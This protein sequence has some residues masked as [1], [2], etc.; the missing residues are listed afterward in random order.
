MTDAK[1][2]VRADEPGASGLG[3]VDPLRIP[4]LER[5][6]RAWQQL[7]ALGRAF[8][9]LA[10]VD[11][12]ARALNVGSLSL[13]LDPSSLAPFLFFP[14]PISPWSCSPRSSWPAGPMPSPRRR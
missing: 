2:S 6:G 11:L 14:S 8:M 5:A 10:L 9:A 13:F 12:L 4:G 1:P 7:P 3:V